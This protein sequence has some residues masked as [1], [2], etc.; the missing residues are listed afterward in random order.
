MIL[1]L[2]SML[3]ISYVLVNYKFVSGAAVGVFVLGGGMTVEAIMSFITARNLKGELPDKPQD[4]EKLTFKT[5]WV[6]Y[7]PIIGAL[8][9]QNF[10]RPFINSGLARTVNPE[11]ALAAY[12][13]A[14]STSWILVGVSFSIHQ[15]V[16]VFVENKE[17]FEK[18]K[19]FVFGVGIFG[20]A[21]LLLLSLTPAGEWLLL[22]VIGTDPDITGAA[23]TTMLPMAF[24]PLVVT[25]SEMY[26]GLLM[27]E[28]RTP[29]LTIS[30]AANL[31]VAMILS[32]GVVA[33]YPELGALL[34]GISML[35]G[36][37]GEFGVVYFFARK[38][39]PNGRRRN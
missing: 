26:A 37:A 17:T 7:V 31:I 39:T 23:L 36:Y 10:I 34:A 30:K 18:V 20:S 11:T 13:V 27:M 8:L 32:L 33:I 29:V 2:A 1:R 35:L 28:K 15:L 24:I 12:Q 21:I 14:Y 25:N 5:T 4:D 38:L 19:R 22:N 16:L 6:F 9:L 3:I